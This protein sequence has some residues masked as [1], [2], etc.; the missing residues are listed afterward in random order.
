MGKPQVIN[1]RILIESGPESVDRTRGYVITALKSALRNIR[2]GAVAIAL[3]DEDDVLIGMDVSG[4]PSS[5][6]QEH[7]ED[8]FEHYEERPAS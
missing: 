4:V 8:L 1:A 2:G 6:L 3:Y 5:E 7:I